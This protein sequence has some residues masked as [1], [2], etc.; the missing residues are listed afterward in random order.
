[1][2]FSKDMD[3]CYRS[4]AWLGRPEA[5]A[6][7]YSFYITERDAITRNSLPEV[8]PGNDHRAIG[9]VN[10]EMVASRGGIRGSA[11]FPSLFD[12]A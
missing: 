11:G 10:I 7:L 6:H 2:V 5:N 3:L 4:A 9:V 8:L 12:P 1:M